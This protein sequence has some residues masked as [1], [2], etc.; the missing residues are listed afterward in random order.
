[1]KRSEKTFI[2]KIGSETKRKNVDF[3][4]LKQNE[5]TKSKTKLNK[6]LL[7]VKQS[8]FNFALVGSENFE[9]KEMKQICMRNV[10]KTDL[11]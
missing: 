2:E 3:F 6:K 9:Q 5:K 8:C 7:E 4:A 1:V 11:V 10:C